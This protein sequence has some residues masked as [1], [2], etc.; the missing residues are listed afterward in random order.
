M[1]LPCFAVVQMVSYFILAPL[2]E[3]PG[4][5]RRARACQTQSRNTGV[6][7]EQVNKYCTGGT[8]RQDVDRVRLRRDGR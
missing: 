3:V 5:T 7:L 4:T 2:K 1:L 8:G 6:A